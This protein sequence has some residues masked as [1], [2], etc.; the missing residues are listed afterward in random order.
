MTDSYIL[1][2]KEIWKWSKTNENNNNNN[3]KE[4]KK[5]HTK[6]KKKKKTTTKKKNKKQQ[7]ILE[8]ICNLTPEFRDNGN[9]VEKRRNCSLGAISSIF[10]NILLPVVSLD[11]NVKTGTRFSR[12]DKRFFKI[13]DVEITRDNC[14]PL[15]KIAENVSGIFGLLDSGPGLLYMQTGY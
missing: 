8:W 10:R 6:K 15:I 13:R 5:T 2:K 11:F 12:R 3:N 4:K 7:H 14:I 1:L 9:I